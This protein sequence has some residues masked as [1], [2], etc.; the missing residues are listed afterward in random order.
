MR[1]AALVALFWAVSGA[2]SL[3]PACRFCLVASSGRCNVSV[4]GEVISVGGTFVVEKI[5]SRHLETQQPPTNR[6][7]K[8]WKGAR[9]PSY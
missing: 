6:R 3:T 1:P 2:D 8:Q 9:S 4:I 7:L 5:G